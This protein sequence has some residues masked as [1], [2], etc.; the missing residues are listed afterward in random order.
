MFAGEKGVQIK[1]LYSAFEKRNIISKTPLSSKSK[2][3]ARGERLRT[4]SN[5]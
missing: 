5:A 3:G 1:V 4:Q 2:I